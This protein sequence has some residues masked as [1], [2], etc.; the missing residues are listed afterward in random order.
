MI[1]KIKELIKKYKELIVYIIFGGLTT[2]VNLAVFTLVGMILGDD[3]YLVT[4]AIAWFAA[5]IFAYIT[6]KIWVFESKSWSGKVLLKEIPSFFAAR[7]FSFLLEEAG[8]FLF[9]D[10]LS[11]DDI[12]INILSFEISGEFIAK[13]ILAVVVVIVNYVLSK[14]V[15]FKKK[16]V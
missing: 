14:L 2:V 13:I 9:V 15:I 3:K 12:S 10:L 8:L 7:V 1:T 4:N 11:F 16:N 5:V 6:N